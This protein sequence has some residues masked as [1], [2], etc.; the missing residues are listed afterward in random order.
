[1]IEN[2]KIL[3]YIEENN[4]SS[5]K[6]TSFE[7]NTLFN[8]LYISN[9]IIFECEEIFFYLVE[10]IGEDFNVHHCL[11]LIIKNLNSEFFYFLV[12]KYSEKISA[13]QREVRKLLSYL[14]KCCLSFTDEDYFL[15]F[16]YFINKIH[17][18]DEVLMYC[19]KEVYTDKYDLFDAKEDVLT[20]LVL[21]IKL[22]LEK[23][24][25]GKEEEDFK[26][27]LISFK[28]KHISKNF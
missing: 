14:T 17:I 27:F 13:N 23:Y 9:S 25:V 24:F 8:S 26:E 19:S 21:K 4:L 10:E 1:M 16:E 2:K 3:K 5:I 18:S 28:L 12:D 6:S 22:D 11:N 7:K 20:N 15:F